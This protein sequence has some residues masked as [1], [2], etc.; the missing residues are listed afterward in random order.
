MRSPATTVVRSESSV[1]Y[2]SCRCVVLGMSAV[3]R[4]LVRGTAQICAALGEFW[5]SEVNVP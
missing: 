1:V 5:R 4:A 2:S 3:D